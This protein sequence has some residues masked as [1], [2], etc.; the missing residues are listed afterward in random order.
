MTDMTHAGWIWLAKGAGAVAGSAIS[1]AY[2]LPNHRRDAAI[3]FAVGVVCGMVFGGAT[4]LKLAEIL[5][6][7]ERLGAAETMLMGAAVASLC[8]WSAIGLALRYFQA[9]PIAPLSHDRTDT[10]HDEKGR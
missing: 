8:A 9:R 2:I 5:E 1:L 3:R 4:G 6:L 7:T 10:L